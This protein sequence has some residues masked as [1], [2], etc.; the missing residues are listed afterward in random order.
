MPFIRVIVTRNNSATPQ[1]A[2]QRDSRGQP[3]TK[4][5]WR[6]GLVEPM[7]QTDRYICLHVEVG[8]TRTSTQLQCSECC[9]QA[10]E[11]DEVVIRG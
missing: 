5:V 6:R 8:P 1:P 7:T 10:L 3:G 11:C 2:E 9:R 4:E